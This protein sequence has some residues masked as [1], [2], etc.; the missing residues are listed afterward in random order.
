MAIAPSFMGKKNQKKQNFGH[1]S[2]KKNLFHLTKG[3]RVYFEA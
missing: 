2:N 3:I 1:I